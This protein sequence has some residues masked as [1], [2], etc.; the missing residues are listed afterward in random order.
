MDVEGLVIAGLLHDVSY[1]E[2]WVHCLVP[3]RLHKTGDVPGDSL[4]HVMKQAHLND[5]VHI[6]L[7]EG[8]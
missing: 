1:S 5:P 8:K 3:L 2:D 6:N 4:P 7:Q